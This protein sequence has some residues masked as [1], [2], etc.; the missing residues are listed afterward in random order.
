MKR[1]EDSFGDLW[2]NN[3]HINIY[4]IGVSEKKKREREKKKGYEKILEEILFKKFHNMRKEI[5][6]RVQEAQRV[7]CM[8]NQKTNTPRHI[9]IKLM[10][11]IHKK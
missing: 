7:L 6:T 1:N 9:L 3:K 10:K 5:A 8:I 2:D 4:T 11:I